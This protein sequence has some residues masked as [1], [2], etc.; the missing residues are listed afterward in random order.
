MCLYDVEFL[1]M[2]ENH[3]QSSRKGTRKK[4]SNRKKKGSRKQ[5]PSDETSC[6]QQTNDETESAAPSIG[7]WQ[8]CNGGGDVSKTEEGGSGELDEVEA[9]YEKYWTEQGEYLV[10]EGWIEKYPD[11]MAEVGTMDGIPAVREVEVCC[12]D[13]E[14]VTGTNSECQQEGCVMAVNGTDDDT[15]VKS[16]EIA[17]VPSHCD[18]VVTNEAM[19]DNQRHDTETHDTAVTCTSAVLN[20]HP[21]VYTHASSDEP[22]ALEMHD[23]A[24]SCEC[25]EPGPAGGDTCQTMSETGGDTWEAR[26]TEH[27]SETYWYYYNQYRQWFGGG[28]CN[29]TDVQQLPVYSLHPLT[30]SE[31]DGHCRD[32]DLAT[33]GTDA[34][35]VEDEC[36][37][38][39]MS[40]QCS[41]VNNECVDRIETDISD[42]ERHQ[43]CVETST[44]TYD[45]ED[46]LVSDS[47]TPEAERCCNDVAEDCVGS[48]EDELSDG[49]AGEK[50]R[51]KQ[52]GTRTGR[53]TKM[54]IK[55]L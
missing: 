22:K 46:D 36:L 40:S 10:W 2:Q 5:K 42:F 39:A 45:L 21:D 31:N 11:Y 37:L 38:H 4:R 55:I 53:L 54:L 9:G 35:N 47:T 26:W 48:Q 17:D 51:R 30:P 20:V 50:K 3:H 15:S 24:R 1:M 6:A 32:S 19:I 16:G 27:Y 28:D 13:S 25:D 23:Y 29:I 7:D 49:G 44:I 8:Q 12:D 41:I 52:K 43:K 14:D 33:D 34:I 18:D